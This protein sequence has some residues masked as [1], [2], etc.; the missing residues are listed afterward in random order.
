MTGRQG[1]KGEFYY[2]PLWNDIH[3]K[4]LDFEFCTMSI[5]NLL[6]IEIKLGNNYKL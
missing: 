5:C 2:M 1:G 3:G 4:H 6:K